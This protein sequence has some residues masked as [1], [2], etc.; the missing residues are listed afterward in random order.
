M[1]GGTWGGSVFD[2]EQILRGD[3]GGKAGAAVVRAQL[4]PS[5]AL[6]ADAERATLIGRA[7]LPDAG[8]PAPVVVRG[9]GVYD[10]SS[11]A[12][13]CSGLL[14]LDDPLAAIRPP[15]TCRGS[16]A[17]PTCWRTRLTTAAIGARRG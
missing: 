14:A 13:T 8:G 2:V 3:R 4:T 15:A 17:L 5:A 11:V 9:D 6:P 7:W 1:S 10:L 12:A 16:A